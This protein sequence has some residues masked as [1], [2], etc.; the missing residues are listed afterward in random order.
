[1]RIVIQ[2]VCFSLL[3]FLITFAICMNVSKSVEANTKCVT[4][5]LQVNLAGPEFASKRQPGKFGQDYQF[6]TA[7]HI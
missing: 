7:V 4:P 2:T 6:P 1:M 3:T 5:K